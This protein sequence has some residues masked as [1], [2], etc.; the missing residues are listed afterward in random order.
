MLY[1]GEDIPPPHTPTSIPAIQ[2]NSSQSVQL[3]VSRPRWGGLRGGYTVVRMRRSRRK[4][5]DTR[6]DMNFTMGTVLYLG[7]LVGGRG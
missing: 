2:D 6:W 1:L 3:G 5:W 4:R 7:G